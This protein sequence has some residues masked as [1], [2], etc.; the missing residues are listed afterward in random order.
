[1]GSRIA[2]HFA[3]AGYPVELLDVSDSASR[4]GL[5]AAAKARPGAFFTTSAA[6]LIRT[7]NFD[8]HLGRA[9]ECDWIVEAVVED[10]AAKRALAA[11]VH[12]FRR[13]GSILSTN[14]S[15]IPL[16]RIS[17]GW[18]AELRAHFLGT[19]FFNPP[20]YLHLVE[21]IPGADTLPETVAWVSD[22]CDRCLGKGVVPCKDTP[23]FIANRVGSFFGATAHRLAVEGD[24]TVEEADLLTGPLIGLPKSATFRLVDIVG[25]DVWAHVLNNVVALAAGDPARERFAVPEFMARMMERG[26]L[27]DKR[28]QGFYKR[29]GKDKE[30]HAIDWKTLEY[31]P[32]QKPRLDA[33][34]AARRISDLPAR[35]R[36][37]V[38]AEDRAGRFLWPLFRDFFRYAAQVAPEISHSIVD[39]DRAIRWGFAFELGPFELWDALGVEETTARMAR[40]GIPV[41]AS[42]E[43]M[44]ASGA[45]SFYA[46]ADRDGQPGTRYFDLAAEAWREV[47]PR[48]GVLSLAAIKR[49]RGVLETNTG[50]SLI[51]L[52]DGVLCVEF[53][54][55]TNALDED[56]LSMVEAGLEETARNFLALAVAKQGENFSAGLS[57]APILRAAEEGDWDRIDRALRRLQHIHMAIKYAL[58]PVVAAPFGNT[59]G[60]G[61]ELVLHA[62]HVQASA[63]TYMGLAEIGA[64][65]I[66]A[67]GGAKEMALRLGD[68]QRVLELMVSAKVSSSAENARELGLLRSRD[69]ISMN[70]ERLPA[71]AKAAALALAG[72]YAP[73]APKV[74]IP[75]EG[76]AGFERLKD[77]LALWGEAGRISG[78][79]FVVA[80]KLAWV[81]SG[82]PVAAG[83]TVSEQDLLD[84]EREGFLGLCGQEK[85]RQRMAHL[86]ET[87]KALRN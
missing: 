74:G 25:L 34:E 8:E 44:L 57:L 66:P 29:V 81:L 53:H 39:I 24:Y 38:A 40:S 73:A 63:E 2:A 54:S 22:F 42:V 75:V 14:T 33:V 68:P 71:D 17:E 64:G 82:G 30:I 3:N 15:G 56:T 61:C 65:L 67:G 50:A 37:L 60:A 46:A 69:G 41:P 47:K 87:G 52:G 26:W 4:Q 20:R 36:A 7:G 77:A 5:D 79:D 1:M 35:L 83:Q 45:R 62:A 31:H 80:E 28:G 59:L 32:A 58:R 18:P 21:I 49:A 70:P 76:V 19:H 9:A 55:R 23:N 72:P 10:L 43:R 27:G 16:A 85:T 48:P 6:G 84:L 12:Q 78:Y 86:L 13:P 11:R 51:D